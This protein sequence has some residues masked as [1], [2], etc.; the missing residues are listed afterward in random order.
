[1][2]VYAGLRC[3]S[4]PGFLAFGWV[5]WVAW[6]AWVFGS[7]GSII[8]WVIVPGV[9][10]LVWGLLC[11]WNGSMYRYWVLSRGSALAY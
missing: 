10:V 1:M 3:A 9:L 11:L 4:Y 2:H 8:S 7:F 6:V 5:A